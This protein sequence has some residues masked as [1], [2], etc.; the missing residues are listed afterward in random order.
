MKRC[1]TSR[2]RRA[3]GARWFAMTLVMWLAVAGAAIAAPKK[4]AEAEAAPTKS[5]V[6]SYMLVILALG[7]GMMAVV[8]PSMRSDKVASR[9]SDDEE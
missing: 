3:R 4:G 7:A 8:R 1:T 6:A 5:Y 9:R 2:G